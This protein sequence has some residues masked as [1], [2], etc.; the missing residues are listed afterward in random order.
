M[1]FG[2]VRSHGAVEGVSPVSHRCSIQVKV[3]V[4][5]HPGLPTHISCV[6][7]LLHLSVLLIKIHHSFYHLLQYIIRDPVIHQLKES[8]ALQRILHF[9]DHLLSTYWIFVDS[10]E[11]DGRKS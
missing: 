7:L 3:A 6:P 8:P 4:I 2:W 10:L 11:V 1:W 9:L 5:D